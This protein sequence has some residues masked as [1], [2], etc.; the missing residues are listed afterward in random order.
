[1]ETTDAPNRD[2]QLKFTNQHKSITFFPDTQLPPF[3]IIT[4]VNG[5]GKT[6]FL[7]A[8]QSGQI[9][10]K[11]VQAN[12]NQIRRFNWN[13]FSPQVEQG[14]NPSVMRQSRENALNNLMLHKDNFWKQFPAFFAQRQIS[15]DST[16]QDSA[17]LF[18]IDEA[19]LV[20]LLKNCKQRSMPFTENGARQVANQFVRQRENAEPQF[21]QQLKQ[22]GDL[23]KKLRE[24]TIE[25]GLPTLFS[26]PE[27]AFREFM[28]L[29][30]SQN[31]LL[32]FQFAS[33]FAA[34]HGAFEYNRINRFYATQ[35]GEVQR[36]FLTDENFVKRFGPKPWEL[37]NRVL[38]ASGIRYRVNHPTT[39]FQNLE[40]QFNLRFCDPTEEL[41]IQ[42][43]DLS[44]GEKIILAI[45]LLLYQTSGE[46][47]LAQMPK[48]LLLDEVD[49][50]LHPSYAKVL[51]DI[52]YNELVL[53][54]GLEVI[55]TT[56]SP[57]TVALAPKGSVFELV[58]K[59]REIRSITPSQATQILA[60]GFVSITSSDVIVITESSED[61]EYYQQ[62]FACC[63][64]HNWLSSIP[65]L[66]FIAASKKNDDADGGGCPQVKNWAAKLHG[67]GLERFR[68]LIDQDSGNKE[69][70]VIKVLRRY[71]IE[72]Y[73]F[74]PVNLCAFLIH[75]GIKVPFPSLT[76]ERMCASELI[77]L[78]PSQ[79][80]ATID[81]L[82]AWLVHASGKRDARESK[83]IPVKYI[84]LS[85]VSIPKWW[86][87]TQGHEL[88]SLLRQHLN[89]LCTQQQRGA[90][91][92]SHREEIIAFQT[93][94]FP[95]GISQDLVEIFSQLQSGL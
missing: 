47:G 32:Q 13:D 16:L 18:A 93:K 69:D 65:P 63:V 48:L 29:N 9:E 19:K 10:V 51:I 46:M 39:S 64:E 5:S 22:Y 79:I 40:M 6:H 28:P 3:T 49:A 80:Q 4:G 31:N 17:L 77:R 12:T 42:V 73:I 15:G 84:G 81:E 43:N 24:L 21:C 36:H 88:E 1:M 91:I 44:S 66:K 90:V 55:L 27:S 58:R 95:E 78:S 75:K 33:W 52:L 50:P 7:E 71:S 87:V 70:A 74:D 34:W 86:I 89:P 59:P 62:I 67:I 82:C 54:C 56:H 20:G 41:K 38:E 68:G 30:W 72:N 25:Q 37:T 60:S 61:S 35:E 14:A 11:G 2:I 85:E 23:E 26:L 94:T 76:L 45:I 57:S 92:R 8:I 83:A 53:K